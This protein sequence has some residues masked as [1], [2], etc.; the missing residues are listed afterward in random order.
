MFQKK[1]KQGRYGLG[2]AGLNG[3]GISILNR[4]VGNVVT[5]ITAKVRE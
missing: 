3:G 1:V 2:S 4:V 5:E